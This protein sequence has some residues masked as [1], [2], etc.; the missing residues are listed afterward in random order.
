N[1]DEPAKLTLDSAQLFN[2]ANDISEQDDLTAAHPEKVQELAATWLRWKDQLRTPLWDPPQGYRSAR[3]SCLDESLAR[4]LDAYA[5]TWRGSFGAITEFVWE[6]RPDGTGSIR[7]GADPKATAT[8]VVHASADSLVIDVS[9]PVIRRAGG[10]M[11][12]LRL[13]N[14]VC[15]ESLSGVVQSTRADRSVVRTPFSATRSR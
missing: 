4:P 10:Q 9:E 14:Y 5:G 11:V 8:R 1:A 6:Q 3:R 12:T 2:L 7:I 15:S 13:V